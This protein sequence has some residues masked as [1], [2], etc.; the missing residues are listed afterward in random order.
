MYTINQAPRAQLCAVM[1]CP[2]VTTVQVYESAALSN[3]RG[4]EE[5]IVHY[6]GLGYS[7][8]EI[9]AFLEDVHGY[10]LR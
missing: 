5:L 1:E 8:Q 3:D 6:A 9:L 10:Q 2:L 7:T 4:R